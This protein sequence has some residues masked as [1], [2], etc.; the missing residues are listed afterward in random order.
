VLYVISWTLLFLSSGDPGIGI[1]VSEAPDFSAV[2][3]S[4]AC[5][6]K[7]KRSTEKDLKYLQE[8]NIN[9]NTAQSTQTW[10][11]HFT[12]WAGKRGVP[13]G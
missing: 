1:E 11:R 9:S 7:F 8:L 10:L 5:S 13:K 6:S 2:A 12:K 4:L 3:E